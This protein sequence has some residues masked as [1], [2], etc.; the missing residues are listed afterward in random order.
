MSEAFP[1]VADTAV[2]LNGGLARGAS[3][4]GAVHLRQARSVQC[5]IGCELVDRP[6]AVAQDAGGALDERR[7]LSEQVTDGL[8]RA[9]GCTVLLADL[10]VVACQLL[11]TAHRPDDV[12]ARR[13]ER[14][15]LPP[16]GTVDRQR[17]EFDGVRPQFSR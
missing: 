6:R 8:I 9:D 12:R 13:H 10:D 1:G 11:C 14:Q 16:R 2:Y 17:A 5:V 3:D 4:A 7:S 15:R